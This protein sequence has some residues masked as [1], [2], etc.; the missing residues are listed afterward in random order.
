MPKRTGIDFSPCARSTADVLAGVDDVEAGHP[1]PDG[2]A[3]HPRRPAAASARGQPAA[4]RRHRH[5]QAEERLRVVG[6]ALGQRVPEHDGQRHRRQPAA[7]RADL[8][9]GGHEHRRPHGDE[10]RVA[11][12]LVIAPRGSSRPAVRGLPASKRASTSRLK[13]IAALRADTMQ[14]QN[15]AERR[16]VERP[17]PRR[18]QRAGQRERQREHRVADPDE[19]QVGAERRHQLHRRP[20]GAGPQDLDAIGGDTGDQRL[21]RIG[22]CPA[23]AATATRCGPPPGLQAA[24]PSSRQRLGAGRASRRAAGGAPAPPGAPARIAASSPKR[25]RSGALARL[26]VPTATRTPEAKNRSSGGAPDAD[27]GVAARAGHQ[28]GADGGEP[29]RARVGELHAVHDQRAA[30]DHAEVAQV[31]AGPATRRRPVVAPRAERLEARRATARCRRAAAGPPRG[32]SPTCTDV[33]GAAARARRR[34]SPRNS[35]GDTE[36]GAWGAG[37]TRT[38]RRRRARA[39][40]RDAATAARPSASRNPSSSWKTTAGSRRS[41]STG[42]DTSALAMSPT[43]AVPVARSLV[44]AR[45]AAPPSPR[46]VGGLEPGAQPHQLADPGQEVARRRHPA[47]Q[48]RQLEVGVGVDQARQQ[49]RRSEVGDA[50]GRRRVVPVPDRR[51][52][53]AADEDPAVGQ[54]RGRHR[55]DPRGLHEQRRHARSRHGSR[56]RRAAASARWRLPAALRAG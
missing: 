35:S 56:H 34:E 25:F 9:R 33:M 23:A 38:P 28:R 2:Q 54:R 37:T 4:D 16:P 49:R 47:A 14:T 45:L 51:D 30:G 39:A 10:R 5:R 8:E 50:I 11:S 52:A 46:V 27:P 18:Q 53:I 17:P 21:F 29:R 55:A 24:E 15:P 6:V 31:V 32:D 48:P 20:G 44:D 42:G 19:R 43:A 12:R 22:A 41:R 1:Q 36:N 40:P 13:P 3:E 26:S 7:Q